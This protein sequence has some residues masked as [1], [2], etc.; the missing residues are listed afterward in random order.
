MEKAVIS[1]KYLFLVF[2]LPCLA[3]GQNPLDFECVSDNQYPCYWEGDRS[4]FALDTIYSY[5]GK[6]SLVLSSGKSFSFLSQRL[7][8]P[9]LKKLYNLPGNSEIK[10]TGRIKTN[11]QFDGSAFIWLRLE[12]ENG[13]YDLDNMDEPITRGSVDWEKVVVSLPVKENTLKVYLGLGVRGE[14]STA[15]F[16]DIEIFINDKP[17]NPYTKIQGNL[18][19]RRKFENSASGFTSSKDKQ[20][21]LT[22][23]LH[24]SKVVGLGDCSHGTSEFT[25]LKKDLLEHV[26]HQGYQ[27]D[28]AIE[29]HMAEAKILNDFVHGRNSLN[30]NMLLAN[31]SCW[32]YRS[33]EFYQFLAWIREHNTKAEKKINIWGIDI[34]K[35]YKAID[36]IER[37]YS[38]YDG[39]NFNEIL[40]FKSY[41]QKNGIHPKQEVPR[42]TLLRH[43]REFK[44]KFE[45]RYST[46]AMNAKDDYNWALRNIQ[47]LYYHFDRSLLYNSYYSALHKRDQYMFENTK[48]IIDNFED[49]QRKLL[50]WA[51][52]GHVGRQSKTLGEH[53]HNH[54]GNSYRVI[55]T[56]F[57]SGAYIAKS[58]SVLGKFETG[59]PKTGSLESFLDNISNASNEEILFFNITKSRRKHS[60][61]FAR[62]IG[63]S[64]TISPF[65]LTDM[66]QFDY[67]IYYKRTNALSVAH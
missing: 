24:K 21:A 66:R 32:P 41:I 11:K 26:I 42:D 34:G 19:L 38:S 35:P 65:F 58:G 33:E 12:D 52:N 46:H 53:L 18:K 9:G 25:L 6:N 43:I 28:L 2:F 5:T 8:Y 62:N 27:T 49:K 4:T 51:H 23:V 63:S 50:V 14:Y 48:W 20:M 15:Y 60:M 3:Q 64:K 17:V 45:K 37:F 36:Q 16:D 57:S 39:D 7:F 59:S 55:A 31:I 56:F 40:Q 47:L 30:K 54:Y 67:I 22:E 1:V 61:F 29:C 10:I 13:P 44:E